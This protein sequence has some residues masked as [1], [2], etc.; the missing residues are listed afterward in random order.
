MIL[1]GGRASPRPPIQAG[2]A[3]T[4]VDD[5]YVDQLQRSATNG[6]VSGRGSSSATPTSTERRDGGRSH[7]VTTLSSRA[8]APATAAGVEQSAANPF[9]ARGIVRLGG[10]A[11]TDRPCSKGSGISVTAKNSAAQPATV[12]PRQSR[13]RCG[14]VQTWWTPSVPAASASREDVNRSPSARSVELGRLQQPEPAG[15]RRSAAPSAHRRGAAVRCRRHLLEMQHHPVGIHAVRRIRLPVGHRSRH[16]HGGAGAS[17]TPASHQTGSLVAAQSPLLPA[18]R[19]AGT[20]GAR[21]CPARPQLGSRDGVVAQ[22]GMSGPPPGSSR[23]EPTQFGGD[24]MDACSASARRFR[25]V[26]VIAASNCRNCLFRVVGAAIEGRPSGVRKHVIGQPP[27][28]GERDG[29]VHVGRR[30]I[31]AFFAIDP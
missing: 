28:P 18:G 25:H 2:P 7:A 3:Q 8:G 9:K 14:G 10:G 16:D 20:S 17:A 24:A 22:L 6:R 27:L 21:P 29:R 13:D 1:P 11:G 12:V 31:G 30:R 23:N 5:M 4:A 15:R 19:R 26:S